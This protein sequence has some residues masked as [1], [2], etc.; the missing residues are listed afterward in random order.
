MEHGTEK[1]NMQTNSGIRSSQREVENRKKTSSVVFQ[2]T[3][4]VVR[5]K[6]GASSVNHSGKL[7]PDQNPDLRVW[8]KSATL[9]KKV[10]I[11][12]FI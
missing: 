3:V 9:L 7:T 4:T 5:S 8:E 2:N 6:P 11:E 1:P 12:N 10:V